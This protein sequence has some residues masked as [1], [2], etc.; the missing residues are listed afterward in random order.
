MK[1]QHVSNQDGSG[2]FRGFLV[3]VGK[4]WARK[5]ERWVARR[6]EYDCTHI[7]A[8]VCV[9]A[10]RKTVTRALLWTAQ[11]VPRRFFSKEACPVFIKAT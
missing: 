1:A 5:G 9:L 4:V 7:M 10:V 6:R 3:N 11:T 2:Y 8:M